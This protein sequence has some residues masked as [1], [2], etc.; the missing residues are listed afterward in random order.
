MMTNEERQQPTITIAD[1][2]YLIEK[3]SPEIRDMVAYYQRWI[4]EKAEAMAEVNKC[5][6]ACRAITLEIT[7]RIQ[8]LE[9]QKT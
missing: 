5:E 4:N 3:L 9:A 6:A 7:K 2:S 1:K 8:D